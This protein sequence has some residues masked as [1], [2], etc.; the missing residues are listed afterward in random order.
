MAERHPREAALR[1]V[2][3]TGA[4]FAAAYGNVGSSIYYALGVV[5][6]L[7]LGLTPLVFLISGLIFI[8]TAATYAEATVMFPEAGGSSSFAR[9]AFNELVSFFAAWGQVLNYVITI[10]ISAFFVPHYL[11]V[12]WQPLEESPGDI[13]AG[14]VLVAALV[15]INVI[16][17]R[18]SAKLNIVLAIGDLA[19]QVVVVVIGIALVFH[20][21]TLVQNVE[22]GVAP[23]WGD[24]ALGIAI[25]MIAYTGIETLSN[26]SEEA[27]DAPR[28]VPRAMGLVLVSVL[29]LFLLIPMVALSAMPVVEEGGRYTTELAT[30]YADNPMLGIVDNL[31][32]SAPLT[33]ALRVYVGLLAA[34]ILTIATN[35]GLIGLSR[36]TFSMGQYRQLPQAIRSIHPRFKTPYVAIMLF[37]ALSA[38]ALI[39]G[40]TELLATMYSFGAMLSFTVAHL[41]VIRLRTRYPDRERPWRPPLNVRVRRAVIP[42]TALLGGLGTLSAWIVVMALNTRTLILGSAWMVIGLTIYLLYRRSQG[43]GLAQTVKVESLTPLG[44][45]EV[46][47]QSVLIAFDEDDP[48]SE[49]TVAT[50]K[51]LAARRRRAIHVIALVH[52]PSHLPLDAELNGGESAARSKLE[53]AKLICGQRVSGSIEHVRLGQAG[54]A[55]VEEAKAIDAAAIVMPL[56]YRDGAPLYGKTLQTVLAKRPCRVIIAANPA[57]DAD[58]SAVGG[59]M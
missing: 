1:R 30:T 42:I 19:T 52:V 53:Q 15:A 54:K 23:T 9:H 16:G 29:T 7:A 44:V 6:V 35:A 14:I 5:A 22:W 58:G 32:M 38:I 49:E 50:A 18:E 26:M 47:Y 57:H 46:E 31:G 3:G 48:F 27:R 43:L 36:I 21:E 51:A 25:G 13:I 55:I 59:T 40:E 8:C 10:A 11:A 12:I 41:A 4:L 33:D 34:V 28:T 37:G 2:H 39:P 17:S 45:E 20:P 56:R 24:F